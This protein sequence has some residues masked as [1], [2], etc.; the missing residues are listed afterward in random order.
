MSTFRGSPPGAARE[1]L[2]AAP[3]PYLSMMFPSSKPARTILRARPGLSR[4][5]PSE[6]ARGFLIALLALACIAVPAGAINTCSNPIASCPCAIVAPGVYTLASTGLIAAPPGN[7]IKVNVPGVTLDLGSATI[8][9]S[10]SSSADI[11]VWVKAGANNVTVTGT[12]GAPATITGFTTGIQIDASSVTLAN[13]IAQTNSVGIRFNGAAAYGTGL[14][15][16]DSSRKGIVIN[17]PGAGS[18]LDGVS[19]DTTLGFSGIELNEVSGALLNNVTVTTSATYG[20]WLRGSSRNTILNFNVSRNTNAGIYLG[21]FISGGLLG[22]AC[23]PSSPPTPPSDA[24]VLASAGDPSS[25]DGPT[26][27]DQAYGIVV[28]TGCIRNRIIGV[29]A[30]GNGNGSFG[31]DAFDGNPSCGQNLWS[32]NQF[33]VVNQ[34]ACM[35]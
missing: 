27:P 17:G 28:S 26:Q 2:R 22:N 34:P 33:G 4:I 21:C 8:S 35:H 19:V 7:C 6:S 10:P 16:H 12:Q 13:V 18:Y 1:C 24:N 9:S 5:S 32:G 15:V 30:T 29:Q 25:A 11:G 14:V 31:V 23:P 3:A 20:I